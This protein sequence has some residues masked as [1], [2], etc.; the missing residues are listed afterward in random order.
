[1]KK[2]IPMLY[3]I[4]IVG[5]MFG[6]AIAGT[7]LSFYMTERLLL[8]A[9]AMGVILLVARIVDLI[10]GFLSGMIV[11]KTSFKYGQYR[12][13][14]IIGPICVAI[15]VIMCFLNPNISVQM[16][17]VIVLLGYILYGGGMSFAQL[18]QNGMMS[19]IAGPNLDMRLTIS[20]KIVQGQ[21]V[22][23]IATALTIMPL[24][25]WVERFGV[26]GYTVVAILFSVISIAA[27]TTLFKGTKEY[28]QYD[29]DFKSKSGASGSVGSMIGDILKNKQILLVM[30]GDTLRF[31]AMMTIISLAMYY[32]TFVAGNPLLISVAMLSQ[33]IAGFTGALFAPS[34]VKKIGKKNAAVTSGAIATLAYTG[35][36]LFAGANPI[37]Y[38]VL[39][40]AGFLGM[41]LVNSCGV[42]LY[43]DCA[44]YQLYKTGKDNKT[45]SM[46]MFGVAIKV[47]FAVTSILVSWVL[48]TSGYDA[49][50]GM[51]EPAR[52]A[53]LIGAVPAVLYLVYMLIYM[54]F[55]K[56]TEEK[57]REYAAHNYEKAAAAQKANN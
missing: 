39:N 51:A 56:I 45:F 17:G 5:Q 13:W 25:I 10:I 31:A 30:L 38:I 33:S 1:M 52:L 29:P 37:L 53:R 42:N 47:G 49:A 50:T 40:S 55:Y 12:S 9:S 28:D 35:L 41:S 7:Y 24:I 23:Q 43:L 27:Q 19:K 16:K 3:F 44:E 18:G 22:A 14:L 48:Q 32:F 21:T 54:F 57:S 4:A 2:N 6:T 34:I 8:T 11:Q 26:D 15:G 20:G 36:A 46:S